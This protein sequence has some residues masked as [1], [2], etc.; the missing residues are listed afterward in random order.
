MPLIADINQAI[1]GGDLYKALKHA[2]ALVS[3]EHELLARM[4][5]TEAAP[6]TCVNPPQADLPA[7]PGLSP[8]DRGDRRKAGPGR[9][10]AAAPQP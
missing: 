6:L 5:G 3:Y 9:S 10:A 2:R 8:R 7:R 4:T 1:L